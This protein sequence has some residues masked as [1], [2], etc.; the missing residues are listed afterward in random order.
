MKMVLNTCLAITIMGLAPISGA[1]TDARKINQQ[2]TDVRKIKQQ[3][4]LQQVKEDYKQKKLRAFSPQQVK[5]LSEDEVDMLY[6]VR[7]RHLESDIDH[8]KREIW[9]PRKGEDYPKTLSA[10]KEYNA[11]KLKLLEQAKRSLWELKE[12]NRKIDLE[13]AKKLPKNLKFIPPMHI[14]D[15]KKVRERETLVRV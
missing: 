10:R 11:A 8:L 5:S 13:R 4:E 14:D 15:V 3:K 1:E 6:W 2:K 9:N 12:S 7:R